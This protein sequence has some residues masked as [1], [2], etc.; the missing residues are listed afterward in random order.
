MDNENIVT[1]NI[2]LDW[3]E[4]SVSVVLSRDPTV[5]EIVEL[6]DYIRAS[7]KKIVKKLSK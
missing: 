6:N 1:E 3:C 7:S 2:K 5:N 4:C